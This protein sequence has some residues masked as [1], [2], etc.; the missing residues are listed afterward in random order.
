[1]CI[2]QREL[3]VIQNANPGRSVVEQVL[4]PVIE[5]PIAKRREH[6]KEE[7]DRNRSKKGGSGQVLFIR[8][9]KRNLTAVV[10][11]VFG[12]DKVSATC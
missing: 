4:V 9:Q 3:A 1:M 7:N 6:R 11:I 8:H 12:F 2:P 10:F 5:S